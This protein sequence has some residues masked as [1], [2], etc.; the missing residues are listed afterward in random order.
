MCNNDSMWRKMHQWSMILATQNL[1]FAIPVLARKTE[2]NANHNEQL[3]SNPACSSC[4]QER[5]Y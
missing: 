2:N 3:T 1:M 5:I 4:K